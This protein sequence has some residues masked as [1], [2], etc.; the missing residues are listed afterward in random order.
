MTELPAEQR[1]AE[2]GKRMAIAAVPLYT[3]NGAVH[4]PTPIVLLPKLD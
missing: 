2:C 1:I 3:V 4:P